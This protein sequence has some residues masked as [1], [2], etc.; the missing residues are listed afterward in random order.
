[1]WLLIKGSV[2]L[3][4]CGFDRGT[5]RDE[6]Q[7]LLWVQNPEAKEGDSSVSETANQDGKASL[8]SHTK[9]I[10]CD[11]AALFLVRAGSAVVWLLNTVL[12]SLGFRLDADSPERQGI[13]V[14]ESEGVFAEVN[15][16]RCG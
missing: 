2:Q 10:A 7:Q 5:G 4:G 8:A 11:L 6:L 3:S 12:T 13:P 15:Y 1:M 9:G 14:I 16:C